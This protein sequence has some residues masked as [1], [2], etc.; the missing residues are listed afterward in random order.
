VQVFCG[1][2]WA[3]D[4]YDVAL[5]DEAGVVLTER[6]I[7]DD[8][9][10]TNCCSSCLPNTATTSASPFRWLSRRREGWSSP[11]C[12]AL[13]DRSM[14]STRCPWHATVSGIAWRGPSPTAS[15]PAAGQHSAHGP[16]GASSTASRRGV[17]AGHCRTGARATRRRLEPP[18][19]C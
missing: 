12:V 11:A 7:D 3:E 8:S 17:G 19:S 5:V 18:T 1:I 15:T 6:R 16:G 9:L 14:R 10:G 13:D 4:H 2:D